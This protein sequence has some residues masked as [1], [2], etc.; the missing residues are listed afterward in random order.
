MELSQAQGPGKLPGVVLEDEEQLTTNTTN[1]TYGTTLTVIFQCCD[2]QLPRR[3][4]T[5]SYK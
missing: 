1:I 3:W 2:E 5:G 4:Q